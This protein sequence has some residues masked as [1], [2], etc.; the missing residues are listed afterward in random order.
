MTPLA[1]TAG[2]PFCLC[3]MINSFLPRQEGFV[4][5]RQYLEGSAEPAVVRSA[6]P[7]E[8]VEPQQIFVNVVDCLSKPLRYLAFD[9]FR[10]NQLARAGV[11]DGH[12]FRGLQPVG[13]LLHIKSHQRLTGRHRYLCVRDVY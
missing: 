5:F 4:L 13:A 8:L 2:C 12:I 1:C 7:Y 3:H 6:F 11:P 9:G 10:N